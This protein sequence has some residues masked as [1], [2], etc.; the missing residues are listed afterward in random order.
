[1]AFRFYKVNILVVFNIIII[2]SSI[3]YAPKYQNYY[4]PLCHRDSYSWL[5]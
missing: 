2:I 5:F 4:A 1:M 3:D